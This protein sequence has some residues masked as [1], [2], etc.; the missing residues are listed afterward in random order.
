[1]FVALSILFDLPLAC[2]KQR[3]IALWFS[4]PDLPALQ[5]SA[6]HPWSVAFALLDFP[7]I[8]LPG[9][10]L[11]RPGK[12]MRGSLV[13]ENLNRIDRGYG[14]RRFATRTG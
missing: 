8:C 14:V 2:Q 1:M 9:C 12:R 4:V 11:L 10:G 13:K 6:L 7:Y 3:F 5:I